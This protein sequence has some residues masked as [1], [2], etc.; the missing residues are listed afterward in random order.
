MTRRFGIVGLVWTGLSA[1]VLLSLVGFAV[2]LGPS[3]ATSIAAAAVLNA[4][5]DGFAEEPGAHR[6]PVLDLHV[7]PSALDSL[8]R[9]LPWSGG[10]SVS[11][12]LI[13]NGVRHKARFR[14]RGVFTPSHF[15]GGKKS[16]RLSMKRS[17][18]WAPYRRLNV[19]NPKA[20]NMV[21]DHMAAWVA[22]SLG[23]A[24]PM[25]EMVFVRIND[26]DCG[27]ME[28][29]EQVDGDFERNRHLHRHEV[30][31][32]K[33]DYPPVADRSLPKGR[34]LWQDPAHWEY[35]SDA[36]SSLAHQRLASLIA[37]LARDSLPLEAHR[38]SIARLIDVDAFLRYQ[39]ALVVINSIHVDQYHNQWLV[40]DPR[41]GRFY[42]VL[43]DALMM[44]APRDGSLYAVHD[45][46]EWWMLRVPDWRLR[47][48]RYVYEALAQLQR[49]G[50]F[51]AR[52]D[53][54]IER[55]RPSVL[56]DRNKYGNVTLQPEDVHRVSLAHVISSLVG[57]RSSVHAYWDRTLARIEAKEVEVTKGD[58]LRLRSSNDAPLLLR[59]SGDGTIVTV[60]GH[61]AAPG[62]ENG[63]WTLVLYR[64]LVAGP[65]SKDH[66]LADKQ[67]MIVEPL[68]AI[69]AF[70][71]GVPASLEILNAITHEAVE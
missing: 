37:A 21:N 62:F 7:A 58:V 25:N 59:W 13:E 23:V 69:V 44:F 52:L 15:L 56:A 12:F 10:E 65:G 31:V 38:D 55:I 40:L 1:A 47:R 16:F 36:D 4:S 46:L 50:G 2:L 34:S 70:E 63:R 49:E 42:P 9:D 26:E 45:A 51:D 6:I 18:P 64:E 5:I 53:E 39:A 48:D 35:A 30:P 41:T 57:F 20:F 11:A 17:N 71:G 33:G 19:I 3:R 68:D 60:N 66:P 67:L 8:Q 43:W 27:V 22:G 28:L 32:Y 54:V 14:Y 29:F 61:L 24:V